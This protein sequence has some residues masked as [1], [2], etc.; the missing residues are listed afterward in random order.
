MAQNDQELQKQI[1]QLKKEKEKLEAKKAV[2]EAEKALI[3]AQKALE[4]TKDTTARDLLEL[5]NKKALAEAR[6]ALSQAEAET[7]Q[8]LSDLQNK[9]AVADAKKG[10]ADS[11]KA[12]E[13]AESATGQQ[14]TEL[15]NQKALIE[16]QKNLADAQTQA[17]VARHI[18][19]VK[20]GPYSGSVDVKEKAGTE[21]ALLL[22]AH[23]AKE[24][25]AK[26]AAIVSRK[27]EKFYIFGA[28]EFPTFQRLVTFRVRKDVARQAF[29]NAR[30][31]AAAKM[32]AVTAAPAL[33]WAG[34]DAASKLLGFFKTD[35]TIG[36]IEAKLEESLLLFAVAGKL[37]DKEVHLPSIY[38]PGA[39]DT[40]IDDLKEELA[41]LAGLR[42]VAAAEAKVIKEVIAQAEKKARAA[43]ETEEGEEEEE[44][45][46]EADAESESAETEENPEEEDTSAEVA[47]HK[48]RLDELNAAIAL[49][50][51]FAGS[52]ITPDSNGN[53]PLSAIAQEF[54]IEAALKKGGAVL[55]LRLENSGGGYLVKKNFLTGLGA[56][57]LYYMGGATV[58]YLLLSGVEG[59]VLAGGVVP[60]YGG[61][62]RAN[63]LRAVLEQRTR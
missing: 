17:A 34:L 40:T 54:A 31:F 43:A 33:I 8:E 62:V 55:L 38:E 46:T 23:A 39:L 21:E 1:E 37:S 26:V 15:Q 20:A 12:L 44:E 61:F 10:L 19:D 14:L 63:E 58:S 36:G 9:K 52:L 3:E 57:P 27:A 53:V 13:Q 11:Q 47:A 29:V 4:Q 16:A 60:V 41:E 24:C 49:Y 50:D 22:A 28:K 32:E 59:R 30:V 18:G 5:Q 56:M 2:A 7:A 25:A 42:G 35:Y 45:E 48:S 51:S 6:K